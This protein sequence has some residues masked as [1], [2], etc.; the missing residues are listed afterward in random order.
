M[1]ATAAYVRMGGKSLDGQTF[2]DEA[3]SLDQGGGRLPLS[4]G[5]YLFNPQPNLPNPGP[6][7]I[8][9]YYGGDNLATPDTTGFGATLFQ[10]GSEQVLAIRGTEPFLDSRIDLLEADLAA[11]GIL[12]V[13]LPQ[14]VSMVNLILRMASPTAERFVPQLALQTSLTRLSANSIPVSGSRLVEDGAG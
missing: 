9:Y 10:Q 3:S 6:W 11:I 2:S 8:Q 12:G 7:T 4:L 13:S 1:L 14:A 5:R